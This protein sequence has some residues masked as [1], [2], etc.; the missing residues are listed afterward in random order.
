MSHTTHTQKEKKTNMETITTQPKGTPHDNTCTN[1]TY[2]NT[3]KYTPH[4]THNQCNN[5]SG[6]IWHNTPYNTDTMKHTRN[7]HNNDTNIKQQQQKKKG[8]TSQTQ[9][10]KQKKNISPGTVYAIQIQ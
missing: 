4:A 9:K 5:D 7:A 6:I 1:V 8:N 3:K 2:T 10:T